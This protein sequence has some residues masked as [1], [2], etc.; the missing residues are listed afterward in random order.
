MGLYNVIALSAE[1]AILAWY[2]AVPY[3]HGC[4]SLLVDDYRRFWDFKQSLGA[5][6]ALAGVRM[7]FF[8]Y[9]RMASKHAP[10]TRCFVF[11]VFLTQAILCAVSS[12]QPL[13]FWREA[14]LSFAR[15]RSLEWG[16]AFVYTL[17]GLTLVSTAFQV[18]Y[19]FQLNKSR[20]LLVDDGF[21][22]DVLFS[23][24]AQDANL[25][26]WKTKWT[27]LV[28]HLKR[29]HTDPTFEAVVRLYAQRD[30]AVDRLAV[31]Y[32]RNPPALEF[33]LP[34]LCSF[35]LLS[36]HQ[37]S[38][39]LCIIL[40]DKCSVSHVFAHRMLWY[41]QSYCLDNKAFSLEE[42]ASRIHMLI[43]EVSARGVEPARAIESP[44]VAV[45][46]GD[47][48]EA[49]VAARSH[50]AEALLPA[51]ED[52]YYTFQLTKMPLDLEPDHA[53]AD[54]FQLES[55]FLTALC[56]VSSNL[57]SVPVSRR[58]DM[59]RT[60][61]ADI[62]GQ[63]LPSN[64]LYLPVGNAHHRLKRIHV[65][66]SFTFSTRERVPF[67]LCAEVVD[68]TSPN[69]EKK[70]R[71]SLFH[72]RRFTLNLWDKSAYSVVNHSAVSSSERPHPLS[73]DAAALGFWSESK[74]QSSPRQRSISHH[75]TSSTDL[76][77]GFF[78]NIVKNTPLARHSSYIASPNVRGTSHEALLTDSGEAVG[79]PSPITISTHG[80]NERSQRYST[81]SDASKHSLTIET[82]SGDKDC[83]DML[84]RHDDQWS[85]R[86]EVS[87]RSPGSPYSP[88][89]LARCDST[90]IYLRTLSER[91]SKFAD[92]DLVVALPPLSAG[93]SDIPTV[94]FKERWI[95][96]ESRLRVASQWG[97]DPGWRLL[98][99]IVKSDDDLRQEQLAS[100][101][102]KQFAKVF[103]EAKLPVFIRSYDVI[104]I[105]ATSGFVEAI[106][107]TISIDSLKRND[108]EYITLLDFFHRHF[109]D[110]TSS[111]FRAARHNF[112]SSLAAYSIVCYLLQIKDRHNG[113]ILLDAEG[114]IIH[115]DFG[116]MLSNN[117][118]NV[119]FEQAPFKLTAE[120]VE[121]MGGP[122]SAT[123]RHFRSLCVRSFLVARK[124]RHRFVLLLEMMINGN[125]HLP[126]FAGDAK[127]TLDR[128]A[129]RFQPQLD[130]NA[131]EDF[132]HALIDAS[133]D[134]WR[135]KWYDK[136]QRWC[137]GV[138]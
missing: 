91:D 13:V 3:S 137:V 135:T 38:P 9:V 40:L 94:I 4:A 89:S 90:D 127:G 27:Q 130:I 78:E 34:Q 11:F 124:Y 30:G 120:F 31:V 42:S 41:L 14:P 97:S 119:A 71:R 47:D 6:A 21:L 66:E 7:L 79:L 59:L 26:S 46:T 45:V 132:V 43:D 62:Q 128:L 50:E 105:S 61:L 12:L 100:Q 29:R 54:P 36:A 109:G 56:A 96:K 102:I 114:H 85:P 52:Q 126:C 35:L 76:F 10:A 28:T 19:T 63:F 108:R 84:H 74:P 115:I 22:Q 15:Y 82:S 136:Y 83:R 39:Q 73:P 75:L 69:E 112:V 60:W 17:W 129:A 44:P 117:P 49:T 131:C 37:Q 53:S 98:P 32:D 16:S 5:T 87:P 64:A 121:L 57:R 133:L 88:P 81:L 77:G 65:T 92:D 86:S 70:K 33:Y 101:L 110:E 113:N 55:T 67:F 125:E 93:R 51:K 68:Y 106:A 25:A 24:G 1:L 123:F 138:F 116:F 48:D 2:I 118:G 23:Q 58:N 99:V 18:V 107:D 95:E 122:R 111:E 134:N 72:G 103:G 104:A 80:Q 20:G 8:E